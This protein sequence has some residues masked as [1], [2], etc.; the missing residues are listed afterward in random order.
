MGC[1]AET[2]PVY[3]FRR[4]RYVASCPCWWSSDEDFAT[5]G[6]ALAVA[7]EHVAESVVA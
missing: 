7:A 5:R 2:T 4:T 1:I 6:E 3:Y